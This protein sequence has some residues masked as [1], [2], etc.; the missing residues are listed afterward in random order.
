MLHIIASN[1]TFF[2][3]ESEKNRFHI[4]KSEEKNQRFNPKKSQVES[5]KLDTRGTD[6]MGDLLLGTK[7]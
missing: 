6:K 5:E 7:V 4:C 3:F 1:L 2:G